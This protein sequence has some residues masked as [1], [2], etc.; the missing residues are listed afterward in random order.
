MRCV[1]RQE[2]VSGENYTCTRAHAAADAKSETPQV[3]LS[4]KLTLL[5]L[6]TCVCSSRY[7]RLSSQIVYAAV[8]IEWRLE[9][10][11]NRK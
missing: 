8:A 11:K 5:I 9:M 10:V 6:Y 7:I 3:P 2:W 1:L 4:V